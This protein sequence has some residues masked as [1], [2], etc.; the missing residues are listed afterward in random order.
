MGLRVGQR[1]GLGVEFVQ[2][3]PFQ[4]AEPVG[5][6]FLEGPSEQMGAVGVDGP[7]E[8]FGQALVEPPWNLGAHGMPERNVNVFVNKTSGKLIFFKPLSLTIRDGGAYFSIEQGTDMTIQLGGF[9]KLFRAIEDY[10]NGVR[11]IDPPEFSSNIGVG[12][13]QN[14]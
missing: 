2:L 3:T 1:E 12:P 10:L 8:C 5:Q 13:L 6:G 9:R 11:R 14:R 4:L 7:R